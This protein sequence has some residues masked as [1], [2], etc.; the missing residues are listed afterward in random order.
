MNAFPLCSAGSRKPEEKSDA[1]RG[2]QGDQGRPRQES[3]RAHVAHLLHGRGRPGQR[4]V[5]AFGGLRETAPAR[6]HDLLQSPN[7]SAGC[8]ALRSL[9]HLVTDPKQEQEDDEGQRNA[10]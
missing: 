1:R 5:K 6:C 7:L 2:D 3:P 10:E 9:G 8:W 4:V